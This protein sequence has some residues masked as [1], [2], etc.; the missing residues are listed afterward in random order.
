MRFSHLALATVALLWTAPYAQAAH[1]CKQGK[2]KG[3]FT[4]IAVPGADETNVTGMADDGAVVG[5]IEPATSPLRLCYGGMVHGRAHRGQHHDSSVRH[6]RVAPLRVGTTTPSERA[7]TASSGIR[8]GHDDR[9]AGRHRDVGARHQRRGN[10]G[11]ALISCP[12]ATM[13]WSTGSYTRTAS[14]RRSITPARS[15]ARCSTSTTRWGLC[16]AAMPPRHRWCTSSTRQRV[17]SP[18]CRS[19]RRRQIWSKSRTR[20]T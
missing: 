8:D 1:S 18:R 7:I 19:V 11:S 14:S 16:S 5:V 20:A 15:A 10:G 2:A 3:T 12:V 4:E 9:R 13:A 6:Q 17:R